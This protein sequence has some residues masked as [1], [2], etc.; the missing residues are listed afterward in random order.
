M[1]AGSSC[2]KAYRFARS[3][4]TESISQVPPPNQRD[5]VPLGVSSDS[6]YPGYSPADHEYG[7]AAEEY[8]KAVAEAKTRGV[9][10]PKHPDID[11]KIGQG[12]GIKNKSLV[13]IREMHQTQSGSGNGSGEDDAPVK[14]PLANGRGG[15]TKVKTDET[16]SKDTDSQT[17]SKDPVF[18]ID[19]KPTPVKIPDH[20]SSSKREAD[21]ETSEPG[22]SKKSKKKHHGDRPAAPTQP[23]ETDDIS[24]EVDA[25]MKEK[26]EKRKR[27]EEKKRKRESEKSEYPTL[28]AVDPVTP[29][30]TMDGEKPK[31]KKKKVQQSENG[32]EL[33]DRT[34]EKKRAGEGVEEEGKKKKKRKTNK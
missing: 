10:I 27:K 15:S 34:M 7:K 17:E 14:Q 11:Y 8:G 13:Q 2:L 26:E 19:T 32:E 4:L 18:I 22:P 30:V 28:E 25:R 31:K 5:Q 9:D 20:L 29:A 1:T 16:A 21:A 23:A 33:P 12:K 24:A 6:M 3:M